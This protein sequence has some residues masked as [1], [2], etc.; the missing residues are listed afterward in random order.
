MAAMD[1]RVVW[2]LQVLGTAMVVAQTPGK[3]RLEK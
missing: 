3:S 1:Q 2:A